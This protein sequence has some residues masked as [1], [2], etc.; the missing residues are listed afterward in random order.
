VE[1]FDQGGRLQLVTLL[2]EGLEPS[3]KVLDIGC[4]F[5]RGG[6]W[7]IHLLDPAC[8]FGIEPAQGNLDAGLKHILEPGLAEAKQPQFAH[9]DDWDF[10]VFGIQFDFVIA[11]S[12]WSHTSK[13][14]MKTMLDSFERVA[15]PG[16]KMLCSYLPTGLRRPTRPLR[17]FHVYLF[18]RDYK[19]EEWV[20]RSHEQDEVGLV[21]H[22]RRWIFNE[23]G[24]RGL[25]VRELSH[26]EFNK[27][28]WLCIE[29]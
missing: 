23:C 26:G 14:Q 25:A 1:F 6:Y 21:N 20:G 3:S 10:S 18:A 24:S 9:N 27:Q 12:V 13:A 5:L 17:P 15:A 16:A 8:Y 29:S 2:L 28:R 22:S 19:G 7:L 11:R 4:G